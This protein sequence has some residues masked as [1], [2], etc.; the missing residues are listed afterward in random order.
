MGIPKPNTASLRTRSTRSTPCIRYTKTTPASTNPTSDGI[1]EIAMIT[2]DR[3]IQNHTTLNAAPVII[4]ALGTRPTVRVRGGSIMAT[5]G[6]GTASKGAATATMSSTY[7]P[8]AQ[9]Y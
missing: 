4:E 2:S 8:A 9:C 5:G 6:A 7:G 1:D 3:G